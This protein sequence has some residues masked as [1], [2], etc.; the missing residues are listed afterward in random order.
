MS[1]VVL[2][3][4]G[5]KLMLLIIDEH[6]VA[7]LEVINLKIEAMNVAFEFRDVG[8][9]SNNSTLTV[10]SLSAPDSQLFIEASCPIDKSGTLFIEDLKAGLLC[11]AF[12]LPLG[13]CSVLLIDVLLL[14]SAY[15]LLLI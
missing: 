9:S 2:C 10:I 8:L 12:L 15:I 1:L 7:L 4:I 11:K 6:G 5:G 3:T 13:E 14:F